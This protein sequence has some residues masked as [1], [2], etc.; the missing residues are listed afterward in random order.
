MELGE[1]MAVEATLELDI[2]E[3]V[4]AGAVEMQKCEQRSDTDRNT[5]R[6]ESQGGMQA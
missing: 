5:S 6:S 1:E 4:R 2:A 3:D